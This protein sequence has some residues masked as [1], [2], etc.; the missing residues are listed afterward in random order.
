MDPKIRKDKLYD[1][2]QF[3]RDATATILPAEQKW[4]ILAVATENERGDFK[5][6]ALHPITDD[7]ILIY[8]GTNT[9]GHTSRCKLF[10][11]RQMCFEEIDV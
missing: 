2:F 8:G 10:D 4:E 5:S 11:A 7:K 1:Q 6:Q 9:F 3:L